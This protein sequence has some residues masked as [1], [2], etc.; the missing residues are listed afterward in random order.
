MERWAANTLRTLGI[1]LIS[2]FV[3]L[4]CAFLLLLSLCAY[5]GGLEGGARHP[6]QGPLYIAAAVAVLISGIW[7]VAVLGRGIA[8]AS[9]AAITR[10]PAGSLS[11]LV[12]NVP[13]HLS[14]AGRKAT[15]NLVLAMGAQVAMAVA[16]WLLNQRIFWNNAA[17][18]PGH[19]WTLILMASFVLYQVPYVVLI[20]ALVKRPDRRAFTYAIAVPAILIM[21]TLF[22][23][24]LIGYYFVR[25]PA[26][27]V[28]LALPFI[29][30]IV[31]LVLAFKAIQQVGLRPEPASLIV[32]AIV[33]FLYF[34]LIHGITPFLYRFV[35]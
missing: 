16:I 4:G 33:T 34:S 11:D 8:R 28:L 21:Q 2:G 27:L 14:P 32:A 15:E 29:M 35:R 30:D 22:S 13:L 23:S 10:T 18:T 3:L 5:N 20:A 1:I 31:I 17:R 7:A 6:E 9:S 26:G 12:P 25:H 19:N 24:S